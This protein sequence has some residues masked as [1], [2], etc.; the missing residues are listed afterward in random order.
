M[1]GGGVYPGVDDE[2][3]D[4]RQ[5]L[6]EGEIPGSETMPETMGSHVFEPG[7]SAS[8]EPRCVEVGQ[9]RA[10]SPSGNAPEVFG[11]TGQGGGLRAERDEGMD[12]AMARSHAA[13]RTGIG[14]REG[15]GNSSGDVRGE[16]C[17][18]QGTVA[19]QGSPSRST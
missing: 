19:D 7:V 17:P 15:S 4:H 13:G 8:N 12:S 2:P 14:R 11:R 6:T 3:C 1:A 5:A 10:G 16:E 9:P 18:R